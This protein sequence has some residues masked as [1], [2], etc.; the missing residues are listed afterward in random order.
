[1]SKPLTPEEIEE[2][3]AELGRPDGTYGR[4]V[5][6]NKSRR[7]LATIEHLQR[8]IDAAE[9]SEQC[10]ATDYFEAWQDAETRLA[11]AEKRARVLE[12]A[13]MEFREQARMAPG[14]DRLLAALAESEVDDEHT[15]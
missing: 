2:M 3:S 4:F 8:Q 14:S 11:E 6:K 10:W 7:L 12:E 5:P 15:R 1:M 9:S 13:L